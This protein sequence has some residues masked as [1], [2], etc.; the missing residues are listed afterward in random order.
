MVVYRWTDGD[1]ATLITHRQTH[2]QHTDTNRKT[3]VMV[4]YGWTGPMVVYRWTDGAD[5]TL[6]THNTQAHTH[7]TA[8]MVV[9]YGWTDGGV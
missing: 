4:V 3:A 6:I 2:I 5:D 9:V 1:D 7:V 8:V